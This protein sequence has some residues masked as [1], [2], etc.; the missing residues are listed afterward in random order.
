MVQ[1]PVRVKP[2]PAD[3]EA[4]LADEPIVTIPDYL[5]TQS[6]GKTS[7]AIASPDA[8][9]TGLVEAEWRLNDALIAGGDVN[10]LAG[11]SSALAEQLAQQ[12]LEQGVELAMH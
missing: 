3:N 9:V 8:H 12:G 5:P 4:D 6:D 10:P 1:M 2:P 7:D 11:H